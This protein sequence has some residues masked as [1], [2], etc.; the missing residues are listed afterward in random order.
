MAYHPRV[1]SISNFGEMQLSK[2]FVT[3]NGKISLSDEAYC[4]GPKINWTS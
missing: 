4:S 3:D 1:A 2:D